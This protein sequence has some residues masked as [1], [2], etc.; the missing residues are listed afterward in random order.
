MYSD[1]SAP[2]ESV[3]TPEADYH[4]DQRFLFAVDLFEHRFYW[5]A[6]EA[7][8]AMWHSAEHDTPLR[9]LLQSLI[10][11]AAAVLQHH[12]GR[13]S[14][15]EHLFRRADSRLQTWINEGHQS[16]YGIRIQGTIDQIRQHL[17]GGPWPTLSMEQR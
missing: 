16:I 11:F 4:A 2:E 8:E 9:D 3:W 5:E 14:G 10:Q 1:G 6:H 15:A 13:Q 12:M 7:W 17:Q